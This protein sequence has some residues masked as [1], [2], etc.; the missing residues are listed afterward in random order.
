M[1]RLPIALFLALT[2]WGCAP[3]PVKKA[4]GEAV[5]IEPRSIK[6]SPQDLLPTRTSLIAGPGAALAIG[7]KL[8]DA[9]DLFKAGDRKA[10]RELPPQL[11][12][13]E[14]GAWGWDDAKQG[15]YF[16]AVTDRAEQV[17]LAME[18]FEGK[19]ADF[20]DALVRQYADLMRA[21]PRQ[22]GTDPRVV[23]YFWDGTQAQRLMI[24]A[25]KV[26]KQDYT[27]TVAIG[28]SRIMDAV[29]MSEEKARG[30]TP[31]GADGFIQQGLSIL[32]RPKIPASTS[33][34]ANQ[35]GP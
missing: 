6:L 5:T 14:Y 23:F 9:Q 12:A 3:A 13:T 26:P 19:D 8:K 27:V 18:M 28:V 25:V 1:P 33:G 31:S 35:P 24:C 4:E 2:V 32:D 17:V 20:I 22:I 7:Q 34:N 16:R 10:V 21:A 15:L 11:L 30:L 29:G